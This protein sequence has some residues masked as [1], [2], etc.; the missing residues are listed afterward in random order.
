MTGVVDE[1]GVEYTPPNRGKTVAEQAWDQLDAHINQLLHALE[2]DE[3]A[4]AQV[5]QGWCQALCWVI[6]TWTPH[7]YKTP[8]AVKLEAAKR[9]EIRTGVRDFEPTPGYQ[10]NPMPPSH[11]DF[12]RINKQAY[13]P[14]EAAKDEATPVRKAAQPRTKTIKPEDIK[15]IKEAMA[16]FNDVDEVARILNIDIN[17]VK[18]HV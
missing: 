8:D 15:L 17:V 4:D 9:R 5:E 12:A 16:M 11:K 13:M 18:S 14:T 6:H 1:R 10:Y 7:Y 2:S 3:Q